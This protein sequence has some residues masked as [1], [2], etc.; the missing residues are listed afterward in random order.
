MPEEGYNR[1]LSVIESAGELEGRVEFSKVVD[2][3]I[4][5]EVYKNL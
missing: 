3:S 1:L 2:N 5:T 4:V